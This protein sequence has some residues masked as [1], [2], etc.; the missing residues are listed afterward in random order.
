MNKEFQWFI[1]NHARLFS[2]YPNKHLVIKDEKV[3]FAEDSIE[4]ALDAAVSAN[5]EFG[6]FIIQECGE[7]SDC[8]RQE[9]HSRVVFA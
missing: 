8:Y 2:E 3:L 5:L 4:S 7:T 1:N 6:S 9:F